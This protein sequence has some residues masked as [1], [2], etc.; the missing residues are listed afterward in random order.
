VAA[1]VTA[2]VLLLSACSGGTGSGRRS[3]GSGGSSSSGGSSD[4]SSGGSY[5][6]SSGGSSSH[7]DDDDHDLDADDLGDLADAGG[8]GSSGGDT[9]G[10]PGS[11]TLAARLDGVWTLSGQAPETAALLEFEG[12]TRAV[13]HLPADR[14]VTCTGSLLVDTVT[15]DCAAWSEAAVSLNGDLLDVAWTDGPAQ[16]YT[17]YGPVR[18]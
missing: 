17:Y 9:G 1:A 14:S 15:L 10:T 6:G 8:T 4:G 2:A 12:D 7:D 5:G 16:T 3:G 11:E 18:P 13:T